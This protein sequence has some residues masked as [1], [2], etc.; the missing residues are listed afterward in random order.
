M[1]SGIETSPSL[2]RCLQD[3]PPSNS[4][5]LNILNKEAAYSGTDDRLSALVSHVDQHTKDGGRA[6]QSQGSE[7]KSMIKDGYELHHWLHGFVE[8]V[9]SAMH[10][11]STLEERNVLQP[12][13]TLLIAD[14]GSLG[15]ALDCMSTIFAGVEGAKWDRE[16]LDTATKSE[17]RLKPLFQLLPQNLRRALTESYGS[18]DVLRR[19]TD[20][21]SNDDE[22]QRLQSHLADHVKLITSRLDVVKVYV[23]R[24]CWPY[25]LRR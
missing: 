7:S 23:L 14:L 21:A 1:A 5:L 16:L 24:P 25:E 19:V 18:K 12:S 3:K 17:Q 20:W 10:A 9:D 11:I 4:E 8:R 6:Q 13:P 2:R 22:F 15:K